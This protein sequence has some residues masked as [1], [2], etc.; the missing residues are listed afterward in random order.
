M[1]DGEN[2]A[3]FV[4]RKDELKLIKEHFKEK[5]SSKEKTLLISGEAGI[6]KTRLI[7]EF[8]SKVEAEEDAMVLKARC[9]AESKTPLMPIK[10]AFRRSDIYHLISQTS[11]PKVISTY[12]MNE[13]GLLLAKSERDQ[14]TALDPDIFTSMLGAVGNFVKDSLS[15]M[16]QKSHGG[17]SGITYKDYNILLQSH[18]KLSLAMVIQ[19]EKNEFLVKDI[20]NTFEKL[21]DKFDLWDGNIRSTEEIEPL[22]SWFVKSGKYD[23]VD[24]VEDPKLKQ[25]NLFDNALYGIQRLSKEN[26]IVFFIDDLQWA[27]SSTLSLLHYLARN[28]KDDRV[29]IIGAYRPEDLLDVETEETHPLK[30]VIQNMSREELFKKIEI[31][32]LEE[33]STIDIISSY[34]GDMDVSEGLLAKIHKESGGNPFF[35]IDIVQMLME[36]EVIEEVDGVWTSEKALQDIHIPSRIYDVVLRRL[37]RLLEGQYDILECASV[38]GEEFESK[39]IQET[40]QMNRIILLK[41][42]NSLEKSHNLIHSVE[43]KYRFDHPK[44]RDVLYE[45]INDELKEEYHRLVA[46]S[47]EELYS[48]RKDEI[49]EV[50]AFQYYK[51]NDE[52]ALDYLLRAG[53][54]S[55]D[56]FNNMEAISFYNEA[57]ELLEDHDKIIAVSSKL[58]ELYFIIGEYDRS[59]EEYEKILD[60]EEDSKKR[61]DLFRKISDVYYNRERFDKA[62]EFIEKGLGELD[63]KNCIEGV[64]LN[65]SLGYLELKDSKYDKAHEILFEV[66]DSVKDIGDKKELGQ[67]YH[68]IGTVHW[69]TGEFKKGL[70]YLK[71]AKEVREEVGDIRDLSDTLNNIAIIYHD[72]GDLDK[73]EEFYFKVIDIE[74]KVGD[75]YGIALAHNNIGALYMDKGESE[76]AMDHYQT[77][78][79]ISNRLGGEETC[80]DALN[81][82]GQVHHDRGEIDEALEKYETCF[83]IWSEKNDQY[84]TAIALNNIGEVYLDKGE[85][86]E[87]YDHTMKSM[88]ICEKIGNRSLSVN[89]Y[90]TLT[91]LSLKNNDVEAALRYAEK[92]LEVSKD[93]NA[94]IQEGISYKLMGM[95]Y[96]EMEEAQKALEHFEKS[97]EIFQERGEKRELAKTKYEYGILLKSMDQKEKAFDSLSEASNLFKD[98]GMESWVYKSDE[99]CKDLN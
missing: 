25:E 51:A 98:I 40:L 59:I 84:S 6:G 38:V 48:D 29:L 49:V 58:G 28:T 2:R 79:K 85:L 18:G 64:R 80:V 99:I 9:L 34:L 23:G 41:N 75:K 20:E 91:N 62:R 44:I 93:I 33:E 55:K 82:I 31:D 76:K 60:I 63:D 14:D 71:E 16:K 52:K 81:N 77:S 37:N 3:E 69:Y 39:V 7:E 53:D 27:D 88:D 12:L 10:E 78:Y 24:L 70:D 26:P 21:G 66:L 13:S 61:A 94:S 92:A 15:L 67:T 72:L 90:S 74:R 57:L 36:E 8:I 47:Y 73:A 96:R 42:L 86:K 50:L 56:N 5:S 97:I 87:A 17:L 19:G 54:K 4:G 68:R 30:K 22:I 1:E 95:V 43:G 65:S 32:R 89:N 45:R 11:N 83:R 35:V 46:E